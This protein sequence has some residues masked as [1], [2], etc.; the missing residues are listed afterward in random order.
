M[1]KELFGSIPKDKKKPHI[2]PGLLRFLRGKFI[3]D[4]KEFVRLRQV[5]KDSPTACC[6]FT[7]KPM[8]DENAQAVTD[9]LKIIDENLF[10][11]KTVLITPDVIPL[12]V[13]IVVQMAASRFFFLL[14]ITWVCD[15]LK[16][17][18]FCACPVS[19]L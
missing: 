10:V 17:Q 7:T 13:D 11:K 5:G 12:A 19:H 8:G 15:R 18:L 3:E 16:I 14:S 6:S 1:Q 2:F 9:R 4:S